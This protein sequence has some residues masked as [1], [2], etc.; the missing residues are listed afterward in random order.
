MKKRLR[1]L[2][3]LP[4]VLVAALIWFLSSQ[5]ILPRPGGIPGFDKVLHF[6]A[7]AVFTGVVCLW[8]SPEKWKSRGRLFALIA[9]VIG[10]VYGI[11]DE[12]HQ[13]FVPGRDC[14]IWDWIADTL[15]SAAGASA[16]AGLMTLAFR[17]TSKREEAAPP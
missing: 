14:S 3:W 11:I 16:F 15:G 13:F 2:Q 10:S 6:A 5:N 7:F 4:A 1:L 17:S 8:F 9:A 12:V